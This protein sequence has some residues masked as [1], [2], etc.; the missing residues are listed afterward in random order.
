MCQHVVVHLLIQY[1]HQHHYHYQPVE[2]ER[3]GEEGRREGEEGE[4][5]R[6]RKGGRQRGEGGGK[7]EEGGGGDHTVHIYCVYGDLVQIN[8][9]SVASVLAYGLANNLVPLPPLDTD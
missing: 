5:G 6:R 2:R 4:E 3:G 1:D 9:L 8:S 7:E